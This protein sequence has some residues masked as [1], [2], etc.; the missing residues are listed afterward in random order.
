MSERWAEAARLFEQALALPH[1]ERDAFVA[2]ECRGDEALADE[3]RSLLA[4]HVEATGFLEPGGGEVRAIEAVAG[5]LAER[6][7]AMRFGAWQVLRPIGE[8]GMGVVYLVERTEGG[9]RQRGALKR[10]RSSM[11][12]EEMIRRFQRERQI[13]ASL[14]HP[15]IARLL[16]GGATAEGLEWLVMEYVEGQPLYEYC[17]ERAL[18]LHERIRLFLEVGE[19][20]AYAHQRLVLHRDIKPGN[21]LVPADGVPRLLDF[22]IAKLFGDDAEAGAGDTHTM[23]APMTPEYASPEQLRGEAVG[24]ASDVYSLGVLL[25]ELL[26]GARPYPPTTGVP[27]FTRVVLEHEPE[28]P[29]TVVR[30]SA[31]STADASATTGGRRRLPE[32]P[33]GGPAGLRRRLAG[34]LDNIVLKSLHKDVGQRYESVEQLMDDL[35]RYLDG[36]PVR[37]RP[38]SWR[39]RATKFARRNRVAIA[40]GTFAAVALV[41]GLG[42]ALWQASVARRESALAEQRF[43]DVHAL[44]QSLLF[45]VSDAI[46]DVPGTT[47]ARELIVRRATEYLE[48]LARQAGGNDALELDLARAYSRLGVLQGT[49]VYANLGHG[50]DA[51][52]SM[53]TAESLLVALERRRPN[54]LAVLSELLDASNNLTLY[55]I[56][57]GKPDEALAMQQQALR[58]NER[59]VALAPDSTSFRIAL[60][61]RRFNLGVALHGVERDSEAVREMRLAI[62]EF[63][64]LVREAPDDPARPLM[65]A[66]ALSGYAGFLQ[67]TQGSVDTIEIAS[68]RSGDLYAA[69]LVKRPDDP[70]LKRRFA[71]TLFTRADCLANRRDR[72][73]EALPLAVRANA[74]MR[75]C[76]ATDPGNVDLLLGEA[77]GVANEGVL[78]A[79]AG[80]YERAEALLN[81]ALQKG[82]RIAAADTSSTNALGPVVQAHASLGD[83]AMARARLAKGAAAPALWREGRAHIAKAQALRAGM[84]ARGDV[85]ARASQ[86]IEGEAAKLAACDSALAALAKR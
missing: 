36:L 6:E 43:E 26:T 71:K 18:S 12:S 53:H 74:L 57:H 31:R 29:S 79:K 5:E 69:A 10:M 39:Y 22:G 65:L 46:E 37:A 80:Q 47:K 85:W 82:L 58:A 35:R 60:P 3:V 25:Y 59:L 77:I 8:G 67:E 73:L 61:K 27:D 55:G 84:A 21:L 48:R 81:D 4:H 50:D 28:R 2:A 38:D 42:V 56:D 68:R 24:T 51:Y 33:A 34:D 45:D 75:E 32:P 78:L 19:A 70:D 20:V 41:G 64:S 86:Q 54:D 72:T 49:P 1:G 17:S 23:H 66:R 13:L 44:A 40:A 15:H 9:F 52:R 11:P 62:G 76:V 63:E 16:D 30:A 14:E 7:G 83:V